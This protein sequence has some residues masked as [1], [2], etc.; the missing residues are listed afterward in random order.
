MLVA[1]LI[2]IASSDSCFPKS[3]LR[4]LPY[5]DMIAVVWWWLGAVCCSLLY[6]MLDRGVRSSREGIV[7]YCGCCN[8][9]SVLISD[10]Q[11]NTNL[12]LMSC[13]W[14]RSLGRGDELAKRMKELGRCGGKGQ[15]TGERNSVQL[16]NHWNSFRNL[17]TV[18]LNFNCN[19]I[20]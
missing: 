1:F 20:C 13:S 5:M 16:H 2:L 14:D 3:M 15:R 11:S 4:P 7:E 6:M 9:S 17:S 8:Q 19:L 10:T 18:H 12:W